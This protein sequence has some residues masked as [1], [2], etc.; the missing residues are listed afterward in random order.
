LMEESPWIR[1]LQLDP[2]PGKHLILLRQGN[3]SFSGLTLV[4]GFNICRGAGKRGAG[5]LHPEIVRDPACAG[6]P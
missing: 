4:G 1:L 2:E 5:K 3:V 6:I